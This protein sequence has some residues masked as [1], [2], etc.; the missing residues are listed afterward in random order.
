MGKAHYKAKVRQTIIVRLTACQHNSWGT[1]AVWWQEGQNLPPAPWLPAFITAIN[2]TPGSWNRSQNVEGEEKKQKG[3]WDRILMRRK[4]PIKQGELEAKAEVSHWSEPSL[5]L[6][7][8]THIPCVCALPIS[9]ALHRGSVSRASTS[10]TT[11]GR[12]G[13]AGSSWAEHGALRNSLLTFREATQNVWLP[14]LAACGK[15]TFLCSDFCAVSPWP[16]AGFKGL[17]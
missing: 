11:A 2:I 17:S 4:R 6:Q 8:C 10:F 5:C 1:A 7:S 14:C 3:A 9:P 16:H 12:Q 13:C 15:I